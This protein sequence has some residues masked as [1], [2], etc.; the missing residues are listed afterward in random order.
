AAPTQS[1][2][3]ALRSTSTAFSVARAEVAVG[4]LRDLPEGTPIGELNDAELAAQ[5][6][7]AALVS[8]KPLIDAIAAAEAVPAGDI[9]GN[10]RFTTESQLAASRA[11]LGRAED[12]GVEVL[13]PEINASASA[14]TSTLSAV[15]DLSALRAAVAAESTRAA[16]DYTAHSWAA[17][18]IWFNT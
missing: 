17:Y 4:E 14:L 2:L 10:S 1:Q 9:S 6:A 8:T 11:V 12:V 16:A 5:N 13:A 3:D 18:V 15:V 7:V